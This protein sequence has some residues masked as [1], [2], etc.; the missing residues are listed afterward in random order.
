MKPHR[1]GFSMTELSVSL[2]VFAIVALTAS[3]S[4]YRMQHILLKNNERQQAILI[5]GNSLEQA[6]AA[7]VKTAAPLQQILERETK[8]SAKP[9]LRP[10]C[11]ARDRD[12]LIRVTNADGRTVYELEL[13]P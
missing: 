10:R 6:R 8:A 3:Q 1:D 11:E 13:R 2:V 12:L 5:V 9:E 4:F 7:G